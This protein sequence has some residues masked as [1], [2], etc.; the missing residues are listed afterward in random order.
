MRVC[1]GQLPG[2]ERVPS[3]YS[4]MGSLYILDGGRRERRN[5][6]LQA[7]GERKGRGEKTQLDKAFGKKDRRHPEGDSGASNSKRLGRGTVL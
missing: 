7:T 1:S 6:D 5:S 4:G 3:F 2:V